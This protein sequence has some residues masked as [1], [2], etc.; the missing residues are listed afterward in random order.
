MVVGIGWASLHR[1]GV[2][3][4]CCCM[5]LHWTEKKNMKPFPMN[6]LY[7]LS[8]R[9]S[10]I[11][12]KKTR[13]DTESSILQQTST[14]PSETEQTS[15]HFSLCSLDKWQYTFTKITYKSNEAKKYRIFQ[16]TLVLENLNASLTYLVRIDRR[17][18]GLGPLLR[19]EDSS[20][21]IGWFC[22]IAKTK[23]L[24][25]FVNWNLAGISGRRR[26]YWVGP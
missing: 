19:P 2:T 15:Y 26:L 23:R 4:S 14:F 13:N 10:A 8:I 6:T 25:W 21:I 5:P 3:F 24:L 22:K 11:S 20:M 12:K 7:L 1:R 9:E 16:S 17:W 18:S